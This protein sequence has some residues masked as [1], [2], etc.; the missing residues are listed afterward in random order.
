MG[1]EHVDASP[2]AFLAKNCQEWFESRRADRDTVLETRECDCC[3]VTGRSASIVSGM[4]LLTLSITRP[5]LRTTC[6]AYLQTARF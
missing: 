3:F 4:Q 6:A 2:C 5:R 1:R